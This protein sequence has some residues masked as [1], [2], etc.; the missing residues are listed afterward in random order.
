MYK[1]LGNNDQDWFSAGQQVLSNACETDFGKR[2][3]TTVK[4]Y[5]PCKFENWQDVFKD[6]IFEFYQSYKNP[7]LYFKYAKFIAL[8]VFIQVLYFVACDIFSHHKYLNLHLYY[9]PLFG[10]A[11]LIF[12]M[13]K[14]PFGFTLQWIRLNKTSCK[15]NILQN[16][17]RFARFGMIISLCMIWFRDPLMLLVFSNWLWILFLEDMHIETDLKHFSQGDL[18]DF[19]GLNYDPSLDMAILNK[20]RLHQLYLKYNSAIFIFSVLFSYTLALLELPYTNGFI[21]LF[22][23]FIGIYNMSNRQFFSVNESSLRIPQV[24]SMIG[25]FMLYYFQFPYL[26]SL[27]IFLF[28]QFSEFGL[29][30]VGNIMYLLTQDDKDTHS[31]SMR[32]DH[33]NISTGSIVLKEKSSNAVFDLKFEKLNMS[34]YLFTSIDPEKWNLIKFQLS[35]FLD[36]N[37]HISKYHIFI[38]YKN[39]FL[40]DVSVQILLYPTVIYFQLSCLYYV[41]LF[42][43][44]KLVCLYLQK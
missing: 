18:W 37:Y 3:L 10:I 39:Q 25:H 36:V 44:F 35:K 19:E 17:V 22:P 30:C 2:M 24:I 38:R 5:I 15:S 29:N 28:W 13:Y 34:N 11:H 1:F 26:Q 14:I 31:H 41:S 7:F 6:Y 16:I 20:Y 12:L 8:N 23:V 32:V 4:D 43:F 27:L 21:M 9:L 42:Y 40:Y 33:R